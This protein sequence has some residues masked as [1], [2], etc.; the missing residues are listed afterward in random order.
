MAMDN[1]R[2]GCSDCKR[3]VAREAANFVGDMVDPLE[4]EV[5]KVAMSR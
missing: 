1:D 5:F 4:D 3:V 2:V